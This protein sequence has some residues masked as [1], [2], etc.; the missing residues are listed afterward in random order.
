MTYNVNVGLIFISTHSLAFEGAFVPVIPLYETT[1]L[2]WI[3]CLVEL[4]RDTGD[5]REIASERLTRFK[6]LYYDNPVS[7]SSSMC[8]VRVLDGPQKKQ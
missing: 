2:G 3:I 4:G 5:C 6:V 1:T 7:E 8:R